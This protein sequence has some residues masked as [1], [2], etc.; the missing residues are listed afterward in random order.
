MI[1]RESLVRKY[2]PIIKGMDFR[3][4]LT[5]GN[6]DFAA[7][8]DVTGLQTFFDEYKEN[9]PLLTMSNWGFHSF[10]NDDGGY[11]S[12]KD[13]EMTEY[14]SAGRRVKYPVE[15]TLNNE[16]IYDWLRVNPHRFNL[17]RMSIFLD[18]ERISVSDVEGSRQVLDMYT[19]VVTSKYKLDGNTVTVT[20]CAGTTDT[21]GVKIQSDLC[22][23]R[24][25]VMLEFP[26][27][28]EDITGSDFSAKK[29]HTTKIVEKSGREYIYRKLDETEY[30]CHVNGNVY[31]N[32]KDL[33]CIEISNSNKDRTLSFA[34]SFGIEADKIMSSTFKQAM[35]ESVF[36]YYSFWNLG[37]MVDVTDSEDKRKE[38]LQ[39]RII[40]SMYLLATQDMGSLPPQETGLTCNS[41][42]GKFHLEMHPV[43]E[44]W[45]ALYGRG[46]YLEKSLK[47]YIDNL[48]KAKENAKRNG[49]KGAR[50]PKMIGPDGYDSPSP[51]APLLTWQQPHVLLMC[52]LLYQSRYSKKRVEVPKEPEMDFLLR[53]KDVIKETAEFM[54]DFLVYNEEK[55]VYEMPSPLYSVQEKGDPGVIKNPPFECLYFSFGLKKAYEWLERIGIKEEEYKK[56]AEKI[57]KPYVSN[58]LYQAYEGCDNTYSIL[59]LD[60]PAQIFIYGW[61]MA[62]YDKKI[63]TDSLKE[64]DRTWDMKS[65]WGWDFA[66]LAMT[67]SRLGRFE[68][69][70][71]QLLKDTE[72]NTYVANG[73][74]AQVSSKNLPLY[75]PG[76]GSLLLAMSVLK[77]C[78]GW[79]VVK[80]G[81]MDYPY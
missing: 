40:T 38:E 45:L 17:C 64:F 60:H 67:Y 53:Y 47:F 30:Y 37:A 63:L 28:K 22:R 75:L 73:H 29:K 66:F 39:R 15:R 46:I 19:G 31:L 71:N 20:T 68:D 78:K 26:Y 58:G 14:K 3:S 49:Y 70:F 44:A 59:N 11:Y 52:D 69:A 80:E 6:G 1:Q 16:K 42:Y 9:M 21:I 12:L 33:H 55:D 51:I 41:W 36:R 34:V 57:A 77:S 61:I 74:N 81:L 32:E 48:D 24:L 62:D 54:A 76:N 27:A 43:H 25:T 79:Y 50:W 4:P 65:L 18:G 23:N 2:N 13:I 72:K 10:K 7:T 5:V 56:I 8:I 35:E